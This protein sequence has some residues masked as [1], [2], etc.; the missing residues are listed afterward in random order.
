[1]RHRE[2]GTCF[3]LFPQAPILPA[4]S[5]P[6]RIYI[7][8]PPALV[9]PGPCDERAYVADAIDKP[10]PYG[11]PY[12]PPWQGLVHAPPRPGPDGHFDHLEQ[13]TR[14][15]A[16]AHL[17]ASV[18][19]TLDIWEGYFGRDI[20][21][22]FARDF[23]R[24]EL[25]PMLDWDNAQSGY[26][27][28][29]TGMHRDRQGLVLPFA[30]SLDTVAHEIGHSIIFSEVGVPVGGHRTAEFLAFHEAVADLMAL[31][32][33]M[34][35]NSVLDHVL[36][37]THGSLYVENEINRIA[38]LSQTEQIRVASQDV[39]MSDVAP[40]W[41]DTEGNWHDAA[42]LD[43]HAHDLGLPLLGAMFDLLVEIYEEV[44]VEQGLISQP[45][46][47]L[48]RSGEY[49][50]ERLET[51]A[52]GFAHAYAGRH[53]QFKEA[54][55]YARDYM[56]FALARALEDLWPQQLTFQRVGMALLAADREMSGGRYESYIRDSFFWRGIPLP[57]GRY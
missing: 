43:R 44:L 53:H 38:E 17:F 31:V 21:W 7:S 42:G 49:D 28:I 48:S 23:P 18:R 2:T 6:E 25:V 30:L 11:F 35:F 55:I 51:M 57:T 41:L 3:L 9:G 10:E 47:R 13:G 34:H 56:G 36:L 40:I 50:P 22:H 20:R 46:D 19:H 14:E 33:G 27:F 8:T 39:R 5:R 26:G 12:L 4:Y 29:E 32:G 45:L 37:T 52:A 1:M 54:L 15:F 24:L 16:A